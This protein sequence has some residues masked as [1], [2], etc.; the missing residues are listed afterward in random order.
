M[1]CGLKGPFV[2]FATQRNFRRKYPKVI[3]KIASSRHTDHSLSNTAILFF[4]QTSAKE[5]ATKN[6]FG[7]GKSIKLAEALISKTEEH[8]N[9]SG[10]PVFRFHEGNQK[11]ATFGERLGNAF[12][13][14]YER[15][16]QSVIAVGNDCPELENVSWESVV[17]ELQHGRAVLGQSSRGGAYLIAL[18][19]EQFHSEGFKNLPWCRSG[20][21][22]ALC[23][24]TQ[25]WSQC[26]I[27]LLQVLRDVNTLSDL[28]KLLK[29]RTLSEQFK[30]I[31]LAITSP[32]A[33]MNAT[34]FR[35]PTLFTNET[36]SLRAP[37]SAD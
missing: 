25:E 1:L 29:G 19:E 34:T 8:I 16:F 36:P 12:R 30:T 23:R 35:V 14:L 17:R 28:K 3:Y 22:E 24:N 33:S 10:L 37:P 32:G 20:L 13:S 7:R 26:E 15:G 11:G 21:F 6:L 27:H 2:K 31:I 9:R 5:A 4:S 18:N